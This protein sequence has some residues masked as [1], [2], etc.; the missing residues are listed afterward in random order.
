MSFISSSPSTQIGVLLGMKGGAFADPT[1]F[2][3]PIVDGVLE[4]VTVDASH[5]Q[6]L[7]THRFGF[8]VLRGPRP[9]ARRFRR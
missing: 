1:V 7:M 5:V 3:T 6:L 2:T 4:T 9:R 8:A